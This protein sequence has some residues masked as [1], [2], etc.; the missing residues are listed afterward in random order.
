MYGLS[1]SR[2]KRAAVMNF[3]IQVWNGFSVSKGCA[4]NVAAIRGA[5]APLNT[6][7]FASSVLLDKFSLQRG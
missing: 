7:V 3:D 1:S 4:A 5:G 2:G 6:M